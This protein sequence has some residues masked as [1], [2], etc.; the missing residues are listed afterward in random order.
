MYSCR[1]SE[2][3][4]TAVTI[5]HLDGAPPR[6]SKREGRVTIGMKIREERLRKEREAMEME[7]ESD[8]GEDKECSTDEETAEPHHEYL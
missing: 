1:M 8:S 6:K 5:T 7:T 4:A 3:N 2:T